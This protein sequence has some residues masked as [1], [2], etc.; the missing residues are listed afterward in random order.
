MKFRAN[1]SKLLNLIQISEFLS[2]FLNISLRCPSFENNSGVSRS[3]DL[4]EKNFLDTWFNFLLCWRYFSEISTRRCKAIKVYVKMQS[5]LPSIMGRSKAFTRPVQT[6]RPYK[7][8]WSLPKL[9]LKACTININA[10]NYI[11]IFEWF[12]MSFGSSWNMENYMW[13]LNS[14][15]W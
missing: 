6:H 3:S 12:L 14:Y 1:I 13:L 11:S 5:L 2:K 15:M 7:A 8:V 9:I 4:F 10:L